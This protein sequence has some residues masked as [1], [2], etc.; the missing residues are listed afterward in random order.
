M[1]IQMAIPPLAQYKISKSCSVSGEQPRNAKLQIIVGTVAGLIRE[2]QCQSLSVKVK[3][4]ITGALKFYVQPEP[5]R[6]FLALDY[7]VGNSAVMT[8]HGHSDCVL[9]ACGGA[10]SSGIK[11]AILPAATTSSTT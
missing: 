8:V 7:E 6:G 5:S 4:S 10:S 9:V 1:G 2:R 3:I 11:I